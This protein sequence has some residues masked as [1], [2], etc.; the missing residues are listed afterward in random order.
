MTQI[1]IGT[2]C[3][4]NKFPPRI[5]EE[6]I[7][8]FNL[9]KILLNLF[10]C[11]CY[12]NCVYIQNFRNITG[13][14]VIGIVNIKKK[15]F[16]HRKRLK[17][18]L[19]A[20]SHRKRQKDSHLAFF[21]GSVHVSTEVYCRIDHSYVQSCK[22]SDYQK[23]NIQNEIFTHVKTNILHTCVNCFLLMQC[24]RVTAN[25]CF[26]FDCICKLLGLHNRRLRLS[27]NIMQCIT[28]YYTQMFRYFYASVCT[29]NYIVRYCIPGTCTQL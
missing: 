24:I 28:I 19:L 27:L 1:I 15:Q 20:F 22:S 25:N 3:I 16:C 8:Q 7:L 5:W 9:A 10:T 6:N 2:P 4:K 11:I 17:D 29:R 23:C 13:I 26:S 21:C 18:S 12:C 14:P